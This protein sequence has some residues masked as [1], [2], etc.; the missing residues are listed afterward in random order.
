MREKHVAARDLKFHKAFES[1]Q[2]E[3]DLSTSGVCAPALMD[4]VIKRLESIESLV[5]YAADAE[6]RHI[7]NTDVLIPK[8]R[9]KAKSAKDSALCNASPPNTLRRDLSCI[10]LLSHDS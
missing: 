3:K 7:D 4:G 1:K 9:D 8:P 10:S 2:T 5:E 6:L